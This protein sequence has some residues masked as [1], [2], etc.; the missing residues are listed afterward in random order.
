MM[1]YYYFFLIPYILGYK[2]HFLYSEI[3]TKIECDLYIWGREKGKVY[4]A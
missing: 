2:S 3:D 4:L 1:Y